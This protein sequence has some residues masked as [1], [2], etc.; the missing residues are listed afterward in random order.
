MR[1][2]NSVTRDLVERDDDPLADGAVRQRLCPGRRWAEGGRRERATTARHPRGFNWDLPTRVAN[3]KVNS[4]F[5]KRRVRLR[6]VLGAALGRLR[7]AEALSLHVED[8]AVGVHTGRRL[9]RLVVRRVALR[10]RNT[11]E[12]PGRCPWSVTTDHEGSPA[13]VR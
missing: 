13:A 10:R 2:I 12:D 11:L 1:R 4:T 7:A 3:T 5:V 6:A 8:R 9:L